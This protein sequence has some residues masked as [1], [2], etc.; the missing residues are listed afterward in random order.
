MN[1]GKTRVECPAENTTVRG[2]CP[3]ISDNILCWNTTKAGTL[4]SQSCFSELNG[5]HYDTSLNASRLCGVDGVWVKTDYSK[6]IALALEQPKEIENPTVLYTTYCYLY[7][8][9]IS[10]VA[11]LAAVSI[12]M[13]FKDL[14]CL[15]NKIHTNLMYTYILSDFTWILTLILQSLIY[16]NPAMCIAVAFF[17][18]YFLLSNF[19]W[20]FVEGLYLYILVV[21]TFTREN[22]KLRVYMFIGWG[23]PLIIMI[24]WS[25]AKI[26][27]PPENAIANNSSSLPVNGVQCMWIDPHP[28]HDWIYQSPAILV[29]I[30]NLIFLARI[31]WV[32]I[33]KLRSA[34]SAETQQFRRA[35]KALLI[36]I[37]LL[38]VTYILT[39]VGPSGNS[40]YA[41]YYSYGRALLLS[42]QGFIVAIF[43][44]FVNSE[45]KNT[46]KHHFIR[47]NDARNL[48][49][50]GSR[51][52]TYSK[53]WS[54]NTRLNRPSIIAESAMGKGK[55]ASTVSSS[56]TMT[57]IVSNGPA[58][59]VSVTNVGQ[60]RLLNAPLENPV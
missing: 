11:L 16:T 56:T 54:P 4:V 42:M 33:T 50:S 10:L 7:G 20:M 52:F 2:W 46:F 32:L 19:F 30:I 57:F 51:R 5:I 40:M 28:V 24:I 15:R 22:I 36:L 3:R 58:G 17:L 45:V 26:I 39:M 38:G 41:N 21:E 23:V 43:Y 60:N 31:M 55:R 29:L 37:P 8:Y 44:C 14:R 47:W 6:C 18:K 34:N 27:T 53:D 48:R 59:C 13:Y 12:F 1:L 35:S 25:V 49:T 9:I